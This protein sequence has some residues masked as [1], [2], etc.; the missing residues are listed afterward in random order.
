MSAPTRRPRS[1]AWLW[2]AVPAERTV[3][4]GR[5]GERSS[6]PAHPAARGAGLRRLPTRSRV[7]ETG[8]ADRRPT[9]A[10]LTLALRS[11]GATRTLQ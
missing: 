1:A 10:S 5:V 2:S 9:M 6:R 4:A 8:R 11:G 3:G 7:A